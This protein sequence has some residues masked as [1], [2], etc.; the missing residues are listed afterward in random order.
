MCVQKSSWAISKNKS[1][2]II[3]ADMYNTCIW[4]H[5]I[6]LY[7]SIGS[8]TRDW[9]QHKNIL[10][11]GYIGSLIH[12][13]RQT[14]TKRLQ[15]PQCD[16]C[17]NF[18]LIVHSNQEL[19]QRNLIFT[20]TCLLLLLSSPEQSY[21]DIVRYY[22]TEKKTIWEHM[23][24]KVIKQLYKKQFILRLPSLCVHILKDLFA[25]FSCVNVQSQHNRPAIHPN[26]I[27]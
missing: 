21:A 24:F 16:V 10:S 17:N 5:C 8:N 27:E 18:L 26:I 14:V 22:K 7:D 19:L 4:T 15:F 3:L 13:F 11:H 12:H 6:I 20:N 2:L 25:H 9:S 23:C 1:V